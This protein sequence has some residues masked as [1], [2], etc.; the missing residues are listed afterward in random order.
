[1]AI[2]DL[3]RQKEPCL[4]FKNNFE[5][6][7]CLRTWSQNL[8]TQAFIV[9]VIKAPIQTDGQTDMAQSTLA[10]DADSEYMF[11]VHRIDDGSF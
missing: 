7:Q 3:Q 2:T 8:M 4:N 10:I 11:I 6:L 1:M 9:S 5:T